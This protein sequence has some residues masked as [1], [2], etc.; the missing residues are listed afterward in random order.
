MNIFEKKFYPCD[1]GTEVIL[2][3]VDNEFPQIYFAIFE[4]GHY[5][6]TRIPFFQRFRW[7]LRL[8]KTGMPYKDEIVLNLD[9]AK[10]LGEELIRL[11]KEW[12]KEINK[13]MTK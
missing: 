6:D 4:N 3:S 13:E 9:T 12:K 7:A 11:Q 2:L 10:E 1:C 8:L 5:K